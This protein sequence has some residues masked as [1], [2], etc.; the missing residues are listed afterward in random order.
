MIGRIQEEKELNRLYEKNEAQFVAVY[1]R[2][3]VGKTYLIDQT[4]EGRI[5]FRHAGLSPEITEPEH[6]LEKQLEHFYNSLEIHGMEK[7]DK[8][9]D[10]LEAFLMLEKFLQKIDDGKTRQLIFIDELPWLDTPR[11]NFLMALE[12]FWNTWA[13]HRKNLMLVVCGSANSW[14]LDNLINAHGGLYNRVTY[15]IKLEPFNLKECEDFFKSNNVKL[16]KYDVTQSYM[17]F[18]GIPYYLG[19]FDGEKSLAQ[20]VDDIMFSKT[21]KLKNEF[22]RLFASVFSKPEVMKNIV[23]LLATK[24]AGFT[25]TEI[26]QKLKISTGGGL[27]KKLNA[28]INSDFIVNYVPFGFSK[29]EEHFKLADPFCLFYLHFFDGSKKLNEKFW[30]QNVTS[31]ALSSWRGFAFENVCFNHIKQIKNALGIS[32]VVSTESAWS[33]RSDDEQGTQIDM[34]ISRNDNVINMCEL[35]FYSDDFSVS[36]EYYKTLMHRENILSKEI[37]PKMTIHNTLITTFGLEKNEYAG[38][39][40]NVITLEQLFC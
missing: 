40:S 1:G 19:Y 21:A 28:L 31:Q 24:N 17:I 23:K 13:C 7:C 30:Q 25:R 15:E 18:G 6:L 26:S 2:R 38:F 11:S 9:K 33:K 8:P 37:S 27:T 29:R 4:F 20:N 39:F 14:I 22:D 34:L 35:K 3:R 16:S 32:G 36:K 12:A 5:T 10:W